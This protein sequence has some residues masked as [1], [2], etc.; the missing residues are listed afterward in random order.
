MKKAIIFSLLPAVAFV[1][2]TSSVLKKDVGKA[3]PLTATE[4]SETE[5]TVAEA[6]ADEPTATEFSNENS[7][8]GEV[9]FEDFLKKFPKKALPLEVSSATLLNKLKKAISREETYDRPKNTLPYE[10]AK[11]LPRHSERIMMS[12]MPQYIE[13]IMAFSNE[14]HFAVVYAVTRGFSRMYR[15]EYIATFDKN[16]DYRGTYDFTSYSPEEIRAVSL[17]KN[18]VAHVKTFKVS[19]EKDLSDNGYEGNSITGIS[20]E[21]QFDEDLTQP[22]D[23]TPEFSKKKPAK[24]PVKKTEPAAAKVK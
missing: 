12:R 7:E 16:G 5:I 14:K 10:Y 9:S 8:G 2:F 22:T 21:N 20:A 4:I 11:H 6:P 23:D 18:L 19:W 1:L 13:P 17:D 24:K 3:Q 15:S